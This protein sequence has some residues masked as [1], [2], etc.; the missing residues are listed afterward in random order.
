[1]AKDVV[2]HFALDFSCWFVNLSDHLLS[3][4][5]VYDMIRSITQL[6]NTWYEFRQNLHSH[7]WIVFLFYNISAVFSLPSHLALIFPCFRGSPGKLAGWEDDR[8]IISSNI[9]T[10]SVGIKLN[11][12]ILC[13]C[14]RLAFGLDFDLD[15]ESVL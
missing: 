12:H 8:R 7:S 1:M 14:I 15:A 5:C 3:K 9:C 11:I 4:S 13:G 6:A 10:F 2:K